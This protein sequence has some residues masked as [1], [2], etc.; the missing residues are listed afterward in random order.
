M[1]TRYI[2][3]LK[4]SGNAGK[5]TSIK[6]LPGLLREKYPTCV[7]TK[8]YFGDAYRD[9]KLIIEIG[10]IK[11]GIE[12][13]GDPNSRLC[14]TLAEFVAQKCNIIICATRMWGQTVDCVNSYS[15]SYEIKFIDKDKEFNESKWDESNRSYAMI[16][17][18][19]VSKVIDTTHK[20]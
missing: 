3:A 12:S 16:L 10:Q 9:I 14:K 17:L 15:K 11:I 7:V 18:D 19:C 8:T 13:Q 1:D 2:F 6:L 4:S 5:T 20:R